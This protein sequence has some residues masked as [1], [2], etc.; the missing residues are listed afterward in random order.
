MK[1][2]LRELTRIDAKA[3][4]ELESARSENVALP[5]SAG[6]F[7]SEAVAEGFQIGVDNGQFGDGDSVEG[8]GFFEPAFGLGEFVELGAVAGEVERKKKMRREFGF[9]GNENGLRLGDAAAG[10]AAGGKGEMDPAAGIFGQGIGEVFGGG[11]G[12]VPFLFL[13]INGAAHGEDGGMGLFRGGHFLKL[14]VG[15]GAASPSSSQP[16]AARRR[17]WS[18]W[19]SFFRTMN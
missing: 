12:E 16:S 9:G 13:E 2:V 17:K 15:G 18:A 19:S 3:D 1:R 4:E 7:A 11:G 8:D 10:F 14:A 5:E 6:E